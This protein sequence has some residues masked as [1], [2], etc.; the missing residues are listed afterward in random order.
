[1][2]RLAHISDLH[3]GRTDPALVLGL[4]ADLQVFGPELC[5]VT[6]DLTQR[7]R[8][9]QFQE[10]QSFLRDLPFPKLVVPGNHDIAPLWQ[11]LQRL[12]APFSRYRRYVAD[13]LDS[14][15]A[16]DELLVLGLSSVRPLRWKEG[17]LA[18][19]QLMW[20]EAQ[21]RRYPRRFHVLAAH[22]PLGHDARGVLE[23]LERA[24]IALVLTGHV[25]RSHSAPLGRPGSARSLLVAGAST[26]TSTRLRGHPNGYNRISLDADRVELELRTWDGRGF[27]SQSTAR[28]VRV[29][30]DWCPDTA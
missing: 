20:A 2:K 27:V 4:A 17:G 6:G 8:R 10:A 25:H 9:T 29:G 18:P 19:R 5:V 3:F 21:V 30:R 14:V 22:H 13:E 24:D 28:Y 1:M 7:A 12:C 26:A 23:A 11:P 15:F 16:D